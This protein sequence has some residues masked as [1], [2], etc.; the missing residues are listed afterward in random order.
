MLKPFNG[1]MPR[2]A[3][4]AFVSEAAYVIGD[5][6]IGENSGV[7]PGAVLRGDFAPIVVGRNTQLEDNCIV[8]TAT[9][10]T[11]GDNVYAGH[12]AVIHC[13]KIGNNVLIGNNATL[14][15]DAEI[16][17]C[18]VIGAGS[19]V[20]ERMKI[21]DRSFAVGVP[22]QVKGKVSDAHLAKLEKGIGIYLKLTREWREQGV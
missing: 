16:G 14:L 11:I 2:L 1:K 5:V 3:A 4:S 21:P 22:A 8:H 10:L 17:N 19:V 18:C 15:D 12:G 6:E 13:A 7:W 9:P 20:T